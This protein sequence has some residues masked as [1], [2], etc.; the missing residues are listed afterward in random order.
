M[1]AIIYPI[2]VVTSKSPQSILD[3]DRTTAAPV[4]YEGF[5]KIEGASSLPLARSLRVRHPEKVTIEIT[6]TEP[7]VC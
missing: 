1:A 6:V 3:H 2:F 5:L 4:D 7:L